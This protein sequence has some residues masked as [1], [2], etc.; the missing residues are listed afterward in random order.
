MIGRWGHSDSHCVCRMLFTLFGSVDVLFV[1]KRGFKSVY[2]SQLLLLLFVCCVHVHGSSCSSDVAEAAEAQARHVSYLV[3]E[4]RNH[5][6]G[7]PAEIVYCEQVAEDVFQEA[8]TIA[9]PI[10]GVLPECLRESDLQYEMEND[11]TEEDSCVFA[12]DMNEAI[13]LCVSVLAVRL[14]TWAAVHDI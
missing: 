7:K 6:H 8:C 9:G 5:F 10:P 13:H 1:G 12:R 2:L 3:E 4:T 14:C 11:N